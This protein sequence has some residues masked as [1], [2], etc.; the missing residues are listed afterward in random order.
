MAAAAVVST[1][2]V[3]GWLRCHRRERRRQPGKTLRG[4]EDLPSE[5]DCRLAMLGGRRPEMDSQMPDGANSETK[6]NRTGS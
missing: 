2:V 5:A 6:L 1:L 3:M 4:H